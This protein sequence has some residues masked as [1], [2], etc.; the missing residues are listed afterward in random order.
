MNS[1]TDSS[2]RRSGSCG[3]SPTVAARGAVTTDPDS[4]A[5]WPDST[6]S[7]VDLPVPFGPTTV[8]ALD[9]VLTADEHLDPSYA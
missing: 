5:R 9:A 6:R 3:R 2:V 7:R 4:G 1:S 8:A